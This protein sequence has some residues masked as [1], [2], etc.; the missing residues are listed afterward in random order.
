MANKLEMGIRRVG[1]LIDFNQDTPEVKV[2]LDRSEKGISVTVPWSDPDSPYAQWFLRDGGR[3]EIPPRPDPLPAPKRV[4]FHDSHGSV[5]LVGCFPRG[6]HSNVMG[7]GSG[8]LWAR[9]AI[10][11][12]DG[13]VNFERPHGMQTE[14]SG[15]RAWLGITSWQEEFDRADG[16]R[17][18]RL[19]SQ[20]TPDIGLGEHGGVSL[21]FR[22]GWRIA[23]EDGGDRRIV[24]DLVHCVTR[25]GDPLAWDEHQQ[26]HRAIRDLL[27]L[28]RWHA[29]SCVVSRVLH[30]DD[31]L[32]TMDGKEHGEQWRDV[33]VPDDSP[34]V[35]PSGF[36]DHLLRFAELKEEG[37]GCWIAL[38]NSFA[39]ALDPVI[40]SLDIRKA[41]PSTM[42]AHTGPGLE[43]LGYLLLVR[44]GKSERVAGSATL[45]ERFDRILADLG[46]CLPFDG[47]TWAAD[48]AKAYNGLKHANRAEPDPVDVLNGWRSSVMV[49]RAWVAIELGTPAVD[50][51][52]R[53]ARDPQRHP[54]VKAE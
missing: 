53:L 36:R 5:L 12:V 9:A 35:P 28:S 23:H 18:A 48:T 16:H 45:R 34:A 31:P 24:H 2:T 39:R 10:M 51:K 43:A 6:F 42:L 40:T 49:V 19:R 1:D 54:Y 46:D 27:V 33:I 47:P 25:G 21:C 41:S 37:I 4:L 11:G 44:D 38:R 15:L 20:H 29:E 7:P 32:R 3:I 52:A 14:I 26:L 13:D 30:K 17:R 22:P 50:V 8:T